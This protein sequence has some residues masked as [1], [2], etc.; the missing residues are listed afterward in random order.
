[1]HRKLIGARY[2]NKGYRS[3]AGPLGPELNS[4]RDTEGHG[5]HTL[6][7]AAGR[8]VPGANLYS[9]GTGMAKGGSPNAR[10]AAY[11]VCWPPT[12]L[13]AECA[14]ADILAAFD[15][16]IQDGVHI[17]S[18]SLGGDPAPYFADG[19]AIG[20]FHAVKNGIIV[21]CSAGN[22]GP[23]LGTVSNV[24]PWILTVGASTIDRE[25]TSF[26]QLRNRMRIKVG[27]FSLLVS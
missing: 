26:V 14:D 17:L 21:V 23:S 25:F 20:S 11:K 13:G 16:A 7:T 1:M 8:M 2:F 18:V 4:P 5:S 19:L 9:H 22:A 3:I 24:A 15:A 27:R 6:S 10:V 12:F